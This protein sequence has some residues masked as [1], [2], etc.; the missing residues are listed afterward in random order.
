MVN[1]RG[2]SGRPLDFRYT[3]KKKEALSRLGKYVQDLAR[4]QKGWVNKAEPRGVTTQV[5]D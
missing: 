2:R 3:L 4:M 5:L 1:T